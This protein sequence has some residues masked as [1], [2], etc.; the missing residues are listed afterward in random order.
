MNHTLRESQLW[1]HRISAQAHHKEVITVCALVL[2]TIPLTLYRLEDKSFWFDEVY[3]ILT[4]ENNW[5]QMWQHLLSEPSMWPYYAL[6][7]FWLHLG[8]S[9]FIVRSLS[10]IFAIATV[11]MV[12]KIGLILFTPRVAIIAAS[13]LPLNAFF[14]HYAQEARGYSL[15]LFLVTVSSYFFIRAIQRPS[16][17]NWLCYIVSSTLAMYT[18]IFAGLALLAHASALLIFGRERPPLKALILCYS[19][20]SLL[21]LPQLFLLLQF[22]GGEWIRQPGIRNLYRVFNELAG[23]SPTLLILYATPC[24]FALASTAK[25]MLK[26]RRSFESWR[27]AFLATWLLLPIAIAFFVSVLL[28]PAFIPRYL[29]ICLSPLVLLVSVGI[30]GTVHRWL[31]VTALLILVVFSGLGL[32]R[33]YT[34]SRKEG[35]REVTSFI[36]KESQSTDAILFYAYFVRQPF[37]YYVGRLGAKDAS[38]A[39]LELSSAPYRPGG[40]N[41]QPEPNQELLETLPDLHPRVWLVLSHNMLPHLGRDLQTRFI[42]K[43]LEREYT[44]V[45]KRNFRGINVLLYKKRPPEPKKGKWCIGDAH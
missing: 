19:S 27:F 3:G 30:S 8:D 1:K 20:I 13:L 16:W 43:A 15:L 25:T 17:R 23:G 34:I 9:E 41:R 2:L 44:P 35:W 42:C 29:I 36:L 28:K 4:S 5:T 38:P 12:Y 32:H 22:E 18:H 11:P 10:A 24:F 37:E 6:L 39:V 45:L 7:H 31:S 14:I 26:Y 33:W 21:V 40:G